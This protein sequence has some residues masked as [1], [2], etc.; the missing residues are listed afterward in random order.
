MVSGLKMS[1]TDMEFVDI[2]LATPTKEHGTTINGMALAQCNGLT[3]T[4]HI[5]ATGKME[6]R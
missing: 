4:S 2:H 3:S 5:L 6:S 1:D